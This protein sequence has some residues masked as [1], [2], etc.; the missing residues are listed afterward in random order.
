MIYY[1]G[2]ISNEFKNSTIKECLEYLDGIKVIGLDI[3]TSFKFNGKYE[4]EGLD[5]HLST[6]CMLQIG[7]EEHQYVIDARCIDLTLLKEIIENE[8]VL[9]VGHNIKFE[10][11]HLLNHNIRLRNV[12]DTMIVERVLYTGYTNKKYGLKNLTKWYFNT[13]VEKD[14]R[15]EF[16]DIKN[17][18]FTVKQINYGA[19]DVVLPLTIRNKQ[20]PIINRK[21]VNNCV[22]LELLFIPVLGDIEYKGMHFNKDVWIKTYNQ[23]IEKLRQLR[24]TLNKYIVRHYKNTYFVK[25]QLD[26]FDGEITCNINWNSPL[27]VTGFFKYINICPQAISKSTK[28]LTYTVNATVIRASLNTINKDISIF[29]YKLIETYLKYKEVKQSCTTFGIDFFKHINPITKRLHSNYTQILETGRISSS[30]PNLQNIPAVKGFRSAFDCPLGY[31]IVNADYSGQEQ[32][33]LA[34]KSND[35]E[36][37]AFYRQK[38]G[39]M[40]SYIAS[41]IFPSLADISLEDIKEYHPDKRQIAKGA[42]FAINYGGDGYTI[43]NN[44]GISIKQGDFVYDA[45]FKA[46]P[47]LRKYFNRIQQEALFR[48]YILIDPITGRKN[49]FRTPKTEKEKNKIKRNALNYP[50]Q[51]EAGSIT[52]YASILFR[53]WILDN[54]LED[55]VFITNIVHDEINVESIE[56]HAQLA[57][58]NLERCMAEAAN[59]WCKIIPL[60][61][62]AIITNYWNH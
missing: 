29:K 46:F 49:W 56:K 41:K 31:K 17:K 30:N 36:L 38:E 57:A 21:D 42:G 10:Y 53:R 58:D 54:Q 18:P 45:Y 33:I 40:H 37:Q 2:E 11:K 25:Q 6:I 1:I 26:L 23:N 62:T 32:I 13:V 55:K 15:L 39:D 8:S 12:Y 47:N 27:Q 14:T 24:D 7:T 50:I 51:G 16:S 48:G 43:S 59:V 35:K 5:P 4:G 3:E 9:K 52:K 28:K 19:N 44:L 61:A 20:L 22:E 60:K 34:N